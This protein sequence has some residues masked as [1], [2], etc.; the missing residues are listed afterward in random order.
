[1]TEKRPRGRRLHCSCCISH[2]QGDQSQIPLHARR[3][4]ANT[5][6]QASSPS[7]GCAT[8]S[9]EQALDRSRS[10]Q[11]RQAVLAT[12]HLERVGQK[13]HSAC[14]SLPC[15][16]GAWSWW[17]PVQRWSDTPSRHEDWNATTKR[18]ASRAP[19]VR[20]GRT[21]YAV[22]L[23]LVYSRLRVVSRA[24]CLK[25][26]WAGPASFHEAGRIIIERDSACSPHW[27]FLAPGI[28][29]TFGRRLDPILSL[30]A[31]KTSGNGR[32]ACSD[33]KESLRRPNP[34]LSCTANHQAYPNRT[35][36]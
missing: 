33:P 14:S 30:G 8:Q 15:L 20:R 32:D 22:G 35:R 11:S 6:F 2:E 10:S 23:G 7:I 12:A 34:A 9:L 36:C 28:E 5:V 17:E 31:R 19:T 24:T 26:H 18:L 21:P 13:F 29:P 1:M 16:R 3:S 4:S 25:I 27:Q